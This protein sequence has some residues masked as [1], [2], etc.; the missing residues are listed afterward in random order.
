M[1]HNRQIHQRHCLLFLYDKD[2]NITDRDAAHQLEEVYGEEALKRTACGKWLAKFRRGEKNADDLEDDTR[3]GRPSHFDEN[4]LLRRVQEDPQVTI[5][6]LAECFQCSVSTLHTHLHAIGMVNKL[7]KW[8]PHQLSDRN[9][10]E[11]VR[12]A[13]ELLGLY[14]SGDL[15]LD[16][17]LTGDEKWVLYVNIVRRRSWVHKDMPALPT[18]KPGELKFGA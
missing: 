17:I 5:R 10:Q 9:K 15:K 8:V 14:Q 11:R 12:V 7:G 2:N 16:E 1:D 4:K 13:Q 3:S 18:A 6:E